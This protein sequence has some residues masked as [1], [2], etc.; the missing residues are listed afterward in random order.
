MSKVGPPVG[1]SLTFL[2]LTLQLICRWRMALYLFKTRL[3][4]RVKNCRGKHF[5]IYEEVSKTMV[6]KN[7]SKI[8]PLGFPHIKKL[9]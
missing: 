8:C 4:R 3:D 9:A 5:Q 1:T 2:I 7:R 6:W